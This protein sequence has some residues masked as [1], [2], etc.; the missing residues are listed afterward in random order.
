MRRTIVLGAVLLVSGLAAY[1]S[2]NRAPKPVWTG[3]AWSCPAGY[4][5]TAGENDLVAGR[6][7]VACSK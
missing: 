5:I 1:I 6:P 4:A 3:S 2:L 7:F